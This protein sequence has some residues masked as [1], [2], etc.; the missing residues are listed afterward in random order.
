MR[1]GFT[2]TVVPFVGFEKNKHMFAGQWTY[3]RRT[4][5]NQSYGDEQPVVEQRSKTCPVFI[6]AQLEST[7]LQTSNV[8]KVTVSREKLWTHYS[9][10]SFIEFG[11]A[12]CDKHAQFSNAPSS[13]ILQSYGMST[14]ASL[15]QPLNIS[16]GTILILSGS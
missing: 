4:T 15:L 3:V 10:M 2:N 14:T 1:L 13:I 6:P 9:P 8:C 12:S 5:D 11:N 16:F 7:Y